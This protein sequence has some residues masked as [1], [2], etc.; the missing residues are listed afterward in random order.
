MIQSL[1]FG[2]EGVFK[3][4]ATPIDSRGSQQEVVGIVVH[5]LGEAENG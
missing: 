1:E 5:T 4:L 3:H 2:Q